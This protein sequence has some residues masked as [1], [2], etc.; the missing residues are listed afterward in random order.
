MARA[1]PALRSLAAR[2][3]RQ[4]ISR[5]LL[6]PRPGAALQ[7]LRRTDIEATVAPEVH[8]DAGRLVDQLPPE[9]PLRLAGWLRGTR[10]AKILARLRFSAP[11]VRDVETLLALHP[12]DAQLSRGEDLQLHRLIKRAGGVNLARLFVLR[13]AELDAGI[14]SGNEAREVRGRLTELRAQVDRVR[15]A[16]E[17]T[18]WR[19]RLAIGGRDV[20]EILGTGP[21]PRVGRALRHLT[22]R[23]QRD[24]DCNTEDALRE[25]L[26]TW[27]DVE[28]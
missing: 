5:L 26:R 7:L 11:L 6:A 25:L 4:E 8:A 15:S 22:E 10:V 2:S 19:T 1:R 14:V 16:G 12:L 21:G 23:V 18:L 20:M 17:E 27:R 3:L 24:P 13:E 28:R 9:L